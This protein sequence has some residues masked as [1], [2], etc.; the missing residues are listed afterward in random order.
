MPRLPRLDMVGIPQH[1]IQ[2]G[3]NRQICFT[4]DQDVAAYCC[5]LQEYA[6]KFSVDIHAWV[7]MTNHVHLLLTPHQEMSVSR[8]MQSLGRSYVRYY[9]DHYFRSGTLWEGRFK[10]CL[11]ESSD[12]LLACYRYI[13]MNPVRAGLVDHP[14]NYHWSS[15]SANGMGVDVAMLTPHDIYLSLGRNRQERLQAYRKL[16][17]EHLNESTVKSIRSLTQRGLVFGSESFKDQMEA[18]LKRR[19][20]SGKPGPK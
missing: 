9:N 19:V 10:S 15:Y 14:G 20:R 17:D 1:V 4:S 7:F 3:N 16:F 5:W 18:S 11:V 8:L 2:R 13:E 12:Y 6:E